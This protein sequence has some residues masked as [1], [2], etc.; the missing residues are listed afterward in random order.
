MVPFY[1]YEPDVTLDAA[2]DSMLHGQISGVQTFHGATETRV[3][4]PIG[5]RRRDLDELVIPIYWC[6]E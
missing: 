1:D 4:G 5:F 3:P 2:G 6:D